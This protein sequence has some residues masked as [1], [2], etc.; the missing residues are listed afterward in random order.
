M[1]QQK[2]QLR[3]IRDFGE[4]FSDTFQFI[5]QEF[6]PLLISFTVIGLS[7]VIIDSVLLVLYRNHLQDVS[8][9]VAGGN[10]VTFST[11]FSIYNST[12][13]LMILVSI[14]SFAAMFTC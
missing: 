2:I 10:N 8:S 3:K 12:F 9:Y 13:F 5:K 7:F 14:I 1:A 6:K 11:L 4:V